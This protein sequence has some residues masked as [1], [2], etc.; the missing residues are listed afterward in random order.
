MPRWSRIGYGLATFVR[1]T[2][3]RRWE[4]E[5]VGVGAVASAAVECGNGGHVVDGELEIQDV[6][7]LADPGN[8]IRLGDHDR[9]ELFG[10]RD[11]SLNSTTAVSLNTTPR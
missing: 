1:L 7:I 4:V 5:G 2:A 11:P 6:V 8:T 10:T 9:A 3:I